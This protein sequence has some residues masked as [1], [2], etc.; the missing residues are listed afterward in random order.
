MEV[1]QLF[2]VDHADLPG[3]H[4]ASSPRSIQARAASPMVWRR[5]AHQIFSLM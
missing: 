2:A 4:A 3:H 1:G 5:E